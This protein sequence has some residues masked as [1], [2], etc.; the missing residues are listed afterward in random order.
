MGFPQCFNLNRIHDSVG[1]ALRTAKKERMHAL[2]SLFDSDL[3]FS[4]NLPLADRQLTRRFAIASHSAGNLKRIVLI[5]NHRQWTSPTVWPG[6]ASHEIQA[7]L[8]WT[9]VRHRTIL[10][11]SSQ[12]KTII[13]IISRRRIIAFPCS[14]DWT[15]T[16]C[17]R[18]YRPLTPFCEVSMNCKK[19][20][21]DS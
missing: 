7:Q 14:M 21:K 3:K 11:F 5:N 10:I 15:R 13:S 12:T 2:A 16:T 9:H 6:M 4:F 20:T 17:C 19:T 8:T 1:K 18:T